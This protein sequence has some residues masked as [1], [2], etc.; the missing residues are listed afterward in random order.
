MCRKKTNGWVSGLDLKTN[1]FLVGG[2]VFDNLPKRF[3]FII[4][5]LE[6]DAI[7]EK[8]FLTSIQIEVLRRLRFYRLRAHLHMGLLL[9]LS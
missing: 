5:I 2:F 4:Y 9:V 1:F 8:R 7:F 6:E 3:L